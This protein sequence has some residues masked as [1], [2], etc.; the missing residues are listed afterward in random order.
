MLPFA[1]R[2]LGCGPVPIGLATGRAHDLHPRPDVAHRGR[3]VHLGR[4]EHADHAAAAGATCAA[5]NAFPAHYTF[6]ATVGPT[7]VRPFGPRVLGR[8]LAAA[9]A[10]PGGCWPSRPWPGMQE[11]EWAP[12][13]W[14]P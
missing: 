9:R 5:S 13:P 8:G 14:E 10:S 6:G 11:T 3:R 4:P 7:R 12:S 2:P 1:C